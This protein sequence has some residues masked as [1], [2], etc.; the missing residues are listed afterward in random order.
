MQETK[1]DVFF[2][3]HSVFYINKQNEQNVQQN[4]NSL[5]SV[6]AAIVKYFCL[7]TFNKHLSVAAAWAHHLYYITIHQLIV[8]PYLLSALSGA[9]RLLL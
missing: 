3:E 1:V 9:V 8:S 2:S 4:N 5:C 6:L 7:C